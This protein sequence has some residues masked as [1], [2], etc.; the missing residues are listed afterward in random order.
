MI[1][2]RDTRALTPGHTSAGDD[3]DPGSDSEFRVTVVA[4]T[5]A[6]TIAALRTAVTLA[7]GL[8]AKIRLVAVEEVPFRHSLDNPPASADF[9]QRRMQILVCAAGIRAEEVAIDVRLCR[10]FDEGLRWILPVRSLVLIGG[11][12][13]GWYRRERALQKSLVDL[14]HQVVFAD[15]SYGPGIR[16]WW[17]GLFTENAA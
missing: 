6:G 14:G 5:T 15:L 2:K 13:F 9:L 17:R 12:R 4:T 1:H 10:D 8:C 7:A 3:L 16:A 11:K